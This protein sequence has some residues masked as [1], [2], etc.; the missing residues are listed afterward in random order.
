MDLQQQGGDTEQGPGTAVQPE[1]E[2]SD[3]R[4]PSY[5]RYMDC[6]SKIKD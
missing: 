6:L 3:H 2:E 4:P 1:W 5:T